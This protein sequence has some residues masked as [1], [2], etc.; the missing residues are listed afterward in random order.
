VPKRTQSYDSWQLNRLVRPAAAA[1][2]LNAARRDSLEMFLVALRK[3][4]QAHQMARV[5]KD[6]NIQR[7]TLYRSLSEAGNPTVN[8]LE[9]ILA[10]VG[11]GIIIEPL[12]VEASSPSGPANP[13]VPSPPPIG[14]VAKDNETRNTAAY[15]Y[16]FWAA[17]ADTLTAEYVA[18]LCSGLTADA[19]VLAMG[20]EL[21]ATGEKNEYRKIA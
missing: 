4:A 12:A 8:T 9:S 7:E 1:A 14:R 6:A 18:P 3:V 13:Y 10:A 11:L 2:F 20:K 5:A 19:I 21:S 15:G 17:T 16:T